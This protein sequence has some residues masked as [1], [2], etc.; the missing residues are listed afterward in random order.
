M[1]FYF[2]GMV[3][4]NQKGWSVSNVTILVSSAGGD[5]PLS[6]YLFNFYSAVVGAGW[7][8]SG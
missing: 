7:P 1:R 5:V 3:D 2:P 4:R 8:A 6:N